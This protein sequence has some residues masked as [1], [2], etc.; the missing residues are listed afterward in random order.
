MRNLVY[1]AEYS[2]AKAFLDK[3]PELRDKRNSIGETVLHFLVVENN[4][5]GVRWL[6][7]NG[8]DPHVENEFG[9]S[10]LFEAASLEYFPM[11]DWLLEN[12]ADLEHKDQN[13]DNIYAYLEDMEKSKSIE[14]LKQ[15]N[16]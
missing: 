8:F 10:T 16:V 11:V 9:Q 1:A 4:I 5:E 15:K 13:G 7:K 14:Y 6:A 2:D 12:G 3:H